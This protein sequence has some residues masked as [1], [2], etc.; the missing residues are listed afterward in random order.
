MQIIRYARP[1]PQ[2]QCGGRPPRIRR[3]RV[4]VATA[5]RQRTVIDISLMDRRRERPR[6]ALSRG[7]DERDP[8]ARHTVI[9]H[10]SSRH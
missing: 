7:S 2:R 10:T 4:L 6:K 3:V 1:L 9:R 8:H 5:T